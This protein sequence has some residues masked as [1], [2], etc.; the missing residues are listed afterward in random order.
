MVYEM[1][2]II[3]KRGLIKENIFYFQNRAAAE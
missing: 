1:R 2:K 3:K